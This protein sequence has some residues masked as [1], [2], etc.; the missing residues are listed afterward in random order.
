MN[1][2]LNIKLGHSCLNFTIKF[3][4]FSN[5]LVIRSLGNLIEFNIWPQTN[6]KLYALLLGKDAWIRSI[7]QLID[8]ISNNCFI[9][10]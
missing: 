7:K 2:I 9:L 6:F 4:I 5:Y 3:I 8:V 10:L 1:N